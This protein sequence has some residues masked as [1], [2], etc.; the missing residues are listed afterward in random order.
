MSDPEDCPDEETL[1]LLVEGDTE[2][3]AA[4]SLRQHLDRCE[5]CQ[6]VVAALLRGTGEGPR[7]VAPEVDLGS[8]VAQ[9]YRVVARLG[10]GAMGVVYRAEDE[11]LGRSVALKLVARARGT[12]R[13]RA[14]R[15]RR[16]AKAMA[17]LRHPRVVTVYDAFVE[18]DGLIIAMAL[19]DGG[20]L[21]DWTNAPR[22]WPE[23]CRV[24]LQAGRGLE[25]VHDAGWIHRD[26][27]PDNVLLDEDG[28]AHVADF[29]L[30]RAFDALELSRVD[31]SVE[32][33]GAPLATQTGQALGTPV[34]MA[35]EQARGESVGVQADVFSFC[36]TAYELLAGVRPHPASTPAELLRQKEAGDVTPLRR[37]VVPRAVADLIHRGLRPDPEERPASM[38]EVC[39]VLEAA[40]KP[41]RSS[42]LPWAVAALAAVGTGAFAWSQTQD[43][44]SDD[45]VAGAL[46]DEARAREAA[47]VWDDAAATE[48]TAAALANYDDAWASAWAEACVSGTTTERECLQQQHSWVAATVAGHVDG[49]LPSYAVRGDLPAV[50][51]CLGRGPLVLRRLPTTVQARAERIA[52]R[53][54]VAQAWDARMSGRAR[55]SHDALTRLRPRMEALD[56]PWVWAEFHH[57]LGEAAYVLD[58]HAEADEALALAVDAASASEHV[59]IAVRSQLLRSTLAFKAGDPELERARLDAAAVALRRA[60]GAAMHDALQAML[61]ATESESALR[62]GDVATARARLEPALAYARTHAPERL[63]ERLAALAEIEAADGN[64]DRAVELY[65]EA[66]TQVGDTPEE[67]LDLEVLELNFGGVLIRAGR[68]D[69]ALAHTRSSMELS[70]SRPD[71]SQPSFE[72]WANEVTILVLAGRFEEAQD[73]CDQMIEAMDASPDPPVPLQLL[74]MRQ[75]AE[76]AGHREDYVTCSERAA[77]LRSHPAFDASD[78]NGVNVQLIQSSCL[79]AQREFIR[80]LDAADGAVASAARIP[81]TPTLLTLARAMRA[82][83]LISTQRHDEALREL[84][85][86][87]AALPPDDP[88]SMR[89]YVQTLQAKALWGAGRK[90]EARRV[91]D[92]TATQLE[93]DDAT[94][95]TAWM[96]EVGLR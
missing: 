10:A 23:V 63:A 69:A 18:D 15:L 4:E 39:G 49:R 31:T 91:A 28:R 88:W 34:Y 33:S 59:T 87:D 60:E 41:R 61:D 40:V 89:P 8:L 7:S 1:W 13:D 42:A 37:G 75:A 53:A 48:R 54:A 36:A 90:D 77:A 71:G 68:L 74:A 80:A 9:R 51:R 52:L 96:Q 66:L 93:G 11:E 84:E 24:L 64:L 21:R 47:R 55:E 16:E 45:D 70:Q 86:A 19:Y 29:G 65:D 62:R 27:K 20:T 72:A 85:A 17:S 56:D 57:A 32:H 6:S 50:E 3:D 94:E 2:P 30:V 76:I 22:P 79:L 26:F 95:F 73:R 25:A 12:T 92:D 46:W 35:P 82:D 38:A 43:P 58:R 5:A 44:C 67:R 14:A 78:D 83:V 81:E